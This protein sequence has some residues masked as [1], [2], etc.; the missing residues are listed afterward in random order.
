MVHLASLPTNTEP[1]IGSSLNTMLGGCALQKHLQQSP[2]MNHLYPCEYITCPIV[3]WF[4]QPTNPRK[5]QG[6]FTVSQAHLA[7]EVTSSGGSAKRIFW[8]F[9]GFFDVSSSRGE[10]RS[11]EFVATHFGW[12]R[13]RGM[14][15]WILCG[16]VHVRIYVLILYHLIYIYMF[17]S[18][19]HVCTYKT[20]YVYI[21]IQPKRL[22]F[23]DQSFLHSP[24]AKWKIPGIFPSSPE[25]QVSM[26]DVLGMDVH[27]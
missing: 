20:Q 25:V 5:W 4:K 19:I 6:S 11:Y 2:N 18:Y 22:K 8:G 17:S 1:R 15:M 27:P 16:D 24:A 3:L 14:S 10:S 13:G 9:L 12:S 23:T 26:H 7:E 21:Y